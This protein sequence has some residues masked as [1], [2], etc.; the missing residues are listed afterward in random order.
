MRNPELK[1]LIRNAVTRIPRILLS[2]PYITVYVN[3]DYWRISNSL[4]FF[5]R[6]SYKYVLLSESSNIVFI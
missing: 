4:Y 6:I 5:V 2:P 3:I 1:Y